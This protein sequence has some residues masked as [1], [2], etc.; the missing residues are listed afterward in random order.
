VPFGTPVLLELPSGVRRNRHTLNPTSVMSAG[1]ARPE[2]ILRFLQQHAQSADDGNGAGADGVDSI[3]I[4]P[5]Q[6]KDLRAI[7]TLFAQGMLEHVPAA[8]R[9]LLL[10]APVMGPIAISFLLGIYAI[11]EEQYLWFLPCFIVQLAL[12]FYSRFYAADKI[13][14][15]VL[16]CIKRTAEE[17]GDLKWDGM[18]AT[19]KFDGA[20]ST[21]PRGVFFVAVDRSNISAGP[22]ARPSLIHFSCRLN[23]GVKILTSYYHSML[24]SLCVCLSLSAW[25]AALASSRRS[26][27]RPWPNPIRRTDP[28]LEVRISAPPMRH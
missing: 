22:Q 20:S 16:A 8:Q 9:A 19:Y 15:Y 18:R 28:L 21:T 25:S 24:I 17:G 3:S 10:S 6:E 14:K 11:N 13:E 12:L 27:A 26:T 2:D 7:C 1:D 23:I 5:A 4:R